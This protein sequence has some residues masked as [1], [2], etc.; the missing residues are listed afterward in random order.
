[1]LIK[2]TVL[3]KRE[4]SIN[5][6]HFSSYLFVFSFIVPHMGVLNILSKESKDLLSFLFLSLGK[7]IIPLLKST[8]DVKNIYMLYIKL[9][10]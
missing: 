8:N 5:R 4:V 7:V 2:P 1:M 6:A 9:L 3:T 10:K